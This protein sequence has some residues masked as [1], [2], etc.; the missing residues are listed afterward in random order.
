MHIAFVNSTRKWGGVKTWTMDYSV[1]LMARGHRVS[2]HVRQDVFLERLRDAGVDARRAGFGFDFNPVSV[3]RLAAAFRRDRPDV[4]VCNIK[5][6]MNIGG[7]A[8]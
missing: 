8:A 4:V 7:M 1:E 3:L 6:D 5:K 2:A